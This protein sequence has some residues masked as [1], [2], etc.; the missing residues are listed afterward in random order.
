MQIK[1]VIIGAVLIVGIVAFLPQTM[2]LI[3]NPPISAAIPLVGPGRP[4][5]RHPS[6]SW[7]RR[8]GRLRSPAPEPARRPPSPS[9]RRSGPYRRSAPPSR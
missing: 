3:P 6:R 7:W 5:A 1:L 2:G 9:A 8:R 4:G